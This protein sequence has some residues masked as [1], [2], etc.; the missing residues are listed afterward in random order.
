MLRLILIPLTLVALA[1]PARAVVFINEVFVNPPGSGTDDTREFIELVGTPGKKLDGY[2][3]AFVNGTQSKYYSL[4]SIPP[5]PVPEPE[6]DEFFSLDG[7]Q[8]GPNGILV[9]G[10]GLQSNYS[11]LLADSN[12]Q[13]WTTIWNGGLDTSTNL[14]NDGS[15]TVLLIRNRPGRTQADPANPAGLRWGKDIP[16][17]RDLF[18]PVVDPQTGIPSDQFG[19]GA[20]DGGQP[21]LFGGNTLDHLGV[22]TSSAIDDLEIVDEVSW[23]HDR[24]WEY[25][26]DDRHVDDGSSVNGLPYRHVHS[27]DDP[28][29]INPDCLARVDYRTTGSGWTPATDGEGELPSGNNWQDTATEQF[30]RGESA[31]GTSGQGSSPFYYFSI[32]ANVDP[33][34]PSIQP[35]ETNVPLWLADGQAPDFNFTTR[36]YQIMAGRVNPLAVPFIPG[37]TDRDGDCDQ[38]DIDKLAAVFGTLDI[39]KVGTQLIYHWIYPNAD[40]NSPLIG[41]DPATQTRPWDVNATGD[42]GIEPS[43]LQWTLNFRGSADG[44]VVGRQ[45]DSTTPATAG[46]YLNPNANVVCT[47]TAAAG[48]SSVEVGQSLAVTV[49]GQLTGGANNLPGQQNGIMQFLH[50]LSLSAGGVFRVQ[51]VEPATGFQS[52]NA[53]PS[54]QVPLGSAGDHGLVN[55][56]G[57]STSFANGLGGAAA[58]YTVTLE[59]I[60]EGTVS[61]SFAPATSWAHFAASTPR[62]LKVGHTASNGDPAQANYPAPITLTATA[63]SGCPGDADCSGAVDFFDIDPFVARLGCPSGGGGCDAGC[64][65]QNSDVDGDGDVDFFDIDP[66]VA[67]LGA[68]CP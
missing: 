23:E 2:A 47:L 60:G 9:I 18:R 19:D 26:F 66:F 62:G 45:Y 56:N 46:V 63:P 50:N 40:P 59:A 55:I 67:Q 33:N 17:D 30:V 43:D 68:T 20:I 49:Y 54:V 3:V 27:L 38:A 64:P 22:A 32:A 57:Y 37:D 24:G 10:I 61:A 65:W 16:I 15:N 7:L 42:N 41:A 8:L 44:R 35:Y 52:I 28:K 1:L 48:A 36:T 21:T 14:Q 6:I 39:E 34:D 29:G 53:S 12:F 13:R 51:S 5:A 58:L 25:D 31:A 11:T 4:N